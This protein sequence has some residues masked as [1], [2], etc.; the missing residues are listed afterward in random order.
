MGAGAQE[1][2]GAE[3]TERPVWLAAVGAAVQTLTRVPV[4]C[5]AAPNERVL[6]WSAVFYPLVG[7]LLGGAGISVHFVAVRFLPPEVT[8]LL[9]LA[10]WMLL[11]G[12]LHEDGLAD[13][14]DAFGS[15]HSRDG[16]L[17][18]MKDSRI[19]VYGSLALA[20]SLLLRWQALAL[21]PAREVAFALIA[22]QV[23]PRTGVVALAWLAGPASRGTG[24]LFAASVRK[25]HLA[26]AFCLATAILLPFGR[27]HAIMAMA[28][29]CLLIVGIAAL[30]FRSRIEGV[31]GDCLGAANQAQEIAVLLAILGLGAV[32]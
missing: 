24:G 26:A 3:R 22:S 23:V 20:I 13:T 11:T 2:V 12:A 1:S 32:A 17:R 18:V 31:T 6:G 15:Q 14:F 25:M 21:L 28:G 27:G 9:V 16:I 8:A 5:S 4:S 29:L 7:L 10:T 30:Y 19:G